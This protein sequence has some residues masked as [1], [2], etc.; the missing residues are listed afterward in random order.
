MIYSHGTLIKRKRMT[1]KLSQKELSEVLGFNNSQF[2]SNVER[3]L[4]NLPPKH[5]NAVAK[6]LKIPLSEFI[7]TALEDYADEITIACGKR[8]HRR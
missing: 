4:A 7:R 5:F 3:G 1:L 6:K 8:S 2:I